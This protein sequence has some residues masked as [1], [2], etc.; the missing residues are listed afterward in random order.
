M[1]KIVITL[2]SFILM[3]T[4][5]VSCEGATVSEEIFKAA[6]TDAMS[7]VTLQVEYQNEN[8]AYIR[9]V[10]CVDGKVYM[11]N[12][13]G[14]WRETTDDTNV[15]GIISAISKH[16]DK[17]SFADGAY[18]AGEL[19][20]VDDKG[21]YTDISN[22][23]ITFD[24]SG[25]AKTITFDE[26]SEN[27][28][29]GKHTLKL[30]SH[31]NTAAPTELSN[32]SGSASD[33]NNDHS[34]P[35]YEYN[36]PEKDQVTILPDQDGS[37]DD[38]VP[39]GDN[40]IEGGEVD[41]FPSG[42][43]DV[44]GFEVN[45][46]KWKKSFTLGYSNYSATF[47]HFNGSFEE[48][49]YYRVVGADV[50]SSADGVSWEKNIIDTLEANIAPFIELF[51]SYVFEDYCYYCERIEMGGL[52]I[53]DSRAEFDGAGRL[54]KFDFTVFGNDCASVLITFDDYG[55]TEAP[56]N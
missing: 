39:G 36:P 33:S 46:E 47:K 44:L 52:I 32:G 50:Y 37:G 55:K 51:D 28:S 6:L 45:A 54:R 41:S 34:G 3:L 56:V 21:N 24:A 13:D 2:I 14:T 16:Y 18:S 43:D 10:R 31:G 5:F 15:L 22:V 23:K 53:G 8:R 30:S 26:V 7:N 25:N 9:T 17:F 4:F 1:K 29:A 20:L 38:Y 19:H 40:V 35:I 11:R 48:I 49:I 12:D 27:G 42:D